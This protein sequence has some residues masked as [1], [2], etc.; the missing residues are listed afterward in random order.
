[1]TDDSTLPHLG[2]IGLGTMGGPMAH[3]LL[4]A[5]YR[6]T[7]YDVNPAAVE[8]IVAAGAR[9]AFGAAEVVQQSEIV[10][11][12]LPSS[13]IFEAVAEEHLLPPAQPG[14]VFI[15]LGTT[16]AGFTRLLAT[17]LAEKGA[18]LIDA[19]VSGGGAGAQAG[20]L[21]MFIGGEEGV[22]TQCRPIFEVLGEPERVV[23]CG[24]SG[25]GQVVKGVNQLAM[26]LGVAA[27]LEAMAYGVQG[28]AE[29]AAM[30]Q[31]VGGDEAWRAHFAQIARRVVEGE[32]EGLVVKF[33]ELPYFLDEAQAQGMN[34]P[35][36]ESLFNFL[37]PLP[38]D[39]LDNMNRP[40]VSF[41]HA[42]LH[43]REPS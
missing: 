17:R 31:A 33:P 3:N 24:S 18:T 2:F 34:L 19:P 8:T 41:W 13:A 37:D 43:R 10:L 6:L 36:T 21:R 20:T 12:S 5:G 7:G 40:T 30:L 9:M 4:N 39:W 29:P 25:S 42:L 38:R 28:G 27:Y 32:A 16:E 14:Q 22:V 23:F 1:M 35:L 15:D 11:T 26:G